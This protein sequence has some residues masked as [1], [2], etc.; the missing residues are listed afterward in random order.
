MTVAV[1]TFLLALVVGISLY[2]YARIQEIKRLETENRELRIELMRL[3]PSHPMCRC[4]TLPVAYVL[5]ETLVAYGIPHKAL[6]GGV[7]EISIANMS[8]A[9]SQ[10]W[11]WRARHEFDVYED[12]ERPGIV[13]ATPKARPGAG[14][15]WKKGGE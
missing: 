15:V 3:S 2:L 13:Y 6:E 8:Y 12:P 1:I 5:N 10:S 7:C 4:A 9:A 14:Y 11:E